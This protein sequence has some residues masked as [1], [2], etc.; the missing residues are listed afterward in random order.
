[1][2]VGVKTFFSSFWNII[3][4]LLIFVYAAYFIMSFAQPEEEYAL[5]SL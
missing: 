4:L 3:D 1:M 2:R 5:K